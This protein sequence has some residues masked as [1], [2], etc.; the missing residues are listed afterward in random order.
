[1]PHERLALVRNPAGLDIG[2][3]DPGEVAV[4]ILAEIVA[5]VAAAHSLNAARDDAS[6]GDERV[7][8]VPQKAIDPICAMEVEVA[9]ALHHAEHEGQTYYFCCA[10]CRAAF[11]AQPERYASAG[12]SS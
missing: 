2:A 11:L 12:R 9:G 6:P 8:G 3:R 5:T 7:A 1:L 10:H 4:S